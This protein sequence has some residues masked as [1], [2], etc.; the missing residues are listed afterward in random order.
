VGPLDRAFIE[1]A[2]EV[3]R[4][5]QAMFPDLADI[6]DPLERIELGSRPVTALV[7]RGPDRSCIYLGE[8]LKCRIHARLG[9]EAKPLLCRMFPYTVVLTESGLRIGVSPRC[10]TYQKTWKGDGGEIDEVTGVSRQ[11]LPAPL[12]RVVLDEPTRVMLDDLN[13][14]LFAFLQQER[15][16]LALLDA[17]ETTLARLLAW[18]TSQ[19]RGR[20]LEDF[21]V[22][23]FAS[24]LP[25]HLR[26][27]GR[28]MLEDERA[29]SPSPSPDSHGDRL[30]RFSAWLK[31]LGPRSEVTLKPDDQAYGFHVLAEFVWI[32]DWGDMST[33]GVGILVVAVGLIVAGWYAAER[34]DD[35]DA[36]GMALNVWMRGMGMFINVTRLFASGEE[37]GR[38][39]DL[40]TS[41]SGS[42]QPD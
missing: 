11:E 23:L 42:A 2:P 26:R 37:V 12:L 3:H 34:E 13:T 24:A 41:G 15:E 30:R 22:A 36:F 35:E 27:L 6:D 32:R 4:Q 38:L 10:Y 40:A 19:L 1:R 29:A 9:P 17:P 8:D 20:E 21:D 31:E 25:A 16:L 18:T 28:A 33:W 14:P 39:L 7:A 5:M